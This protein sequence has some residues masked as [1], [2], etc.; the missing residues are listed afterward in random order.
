MSNKV[1]KNIVDMDA[2]EEYQNKNTDPYGAACVTVARNVMLYLDE[3]PTEFELGYSPNMKTTHGI[4]CHCDTVGGITG[5][6][7]GYVT[8]MVSRCYK[9]GWKFLLADTLVGCNM[10]DE[11]IKKA[12]KSSMAVVLKQMQDTMLEYVNSLNVGDQKC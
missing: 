6:M 4:I 8:T 9:D 1:I 2:W 5:F 10:T 3:N 11:H 7:A 12:I